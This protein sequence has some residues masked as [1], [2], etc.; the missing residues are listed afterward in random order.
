MNEKSFKS[1]LDLY[2]TILK[3]NKGENDTNVDSTLVNPM[4]SKLKTEK[5][6]IIL[7]AKNFSYFKNDDF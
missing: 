6:N 3:K 7:N 1:I 4:I 5:E 2:S